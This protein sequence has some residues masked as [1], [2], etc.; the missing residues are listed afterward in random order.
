MHHDHRRLSAAA[1]RVEAAGAGA[2]RA[3]A[4]AC[5]AAT[6]AVTRGATSVLDAEGG[7]HE[8]HACQCRPENQTVHGKLHSR[9]KLN[10]TLHVTTRERG[11]RTFGLR[12]TPR[13]TCPWDGKTGQGGRFS[14]ARR[15]NESAPVGSGWP[16]TPR[17]IPGSGRAHAG[18]AERLFQAP[19]PA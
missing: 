7:V 15:R 1:P 3:L 11:E 13:N 5:F 14:S 16:V 17:H 19:R 18:R 4:A 10:R 9:K 2:G 6:T 12:R 8:G